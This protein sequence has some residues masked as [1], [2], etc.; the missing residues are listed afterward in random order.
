MD[1]I[2]EALADAMSKLEGAI[3]AADKDAARL[4]ARILKAVHELL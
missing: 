3:D 2:K 1:K 4:Y